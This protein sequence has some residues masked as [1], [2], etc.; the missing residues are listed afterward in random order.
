MKLNLN[1]EFIFNVNNAY[2]HEGQQWLKHLPIL[3]EKLT[4]Q[5]QLEFLHP[6][7]NLTY[8]F[9]SLVLLNGRR[10]ILKLA[11]RNG[12]ILT[13]IKWLTCMEKGVPSVLLMSENDH[14][15]VME[16]LEPGISLKKLVIERKDDQATKI[17][18]D[19][20]KNLQAQHRSG[21]VFKHISEF[22][23]DFE[24]LNHNFD[25]KLLS[26]A[27]S[28]FNQLTSQRHDDVVLHGDL[29]HDNILSADTTWKAIDPHGYMGDPVAEVGAMFKN[30]L[31][32]YPNHLPLQRIIERRLNIMIDE[33]PF[34]KQKIRA[35]A[36]CLTVLSAAWYFEDH[37]QVSDLV[38]QVAIAISTIRC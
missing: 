37:Q 24:I 12:N 30:P 7:P 21:C 4:A 10:A 15:F 6:L 23:K 20:I 29:H 28:W 11:P 3:I 33:L 16:Y 31:D 18:C 35:W 8:S 5:W 22:A 14:A 2:G 27:K 36:F 13:E 25:A 38:T 26:Q 34:D 1:N 19:V 9:V 32:C 17:I